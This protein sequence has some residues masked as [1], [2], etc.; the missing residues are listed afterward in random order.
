VARTGVPFVEAE[1]PSGPNE[2]ERVSPPLWDSER[3]GAGE[4]KNLS[5]TRLSQFVTTFKVTTCDLKRQQTFEMPIWHLKFEPIT[6]CDRFSLRASSVMSWRSGQN[7]KSQFVISNG[8]RTCFNS[9]GVGS[10]SPALTVRAGRAR[11]GYA[12]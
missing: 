4:G 2:R 12:G 5:R 7:L 3:H 11:N 6:D 8:A 9:N 1:D 10:F